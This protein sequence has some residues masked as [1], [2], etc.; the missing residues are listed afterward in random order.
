MLV[1][2]PG[3]LIIG[4]HKPPVVLAGRVLPASGRGLS[5]LLAKVSSSAQ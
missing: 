2:G 1:N 4:R 3:T 5:H